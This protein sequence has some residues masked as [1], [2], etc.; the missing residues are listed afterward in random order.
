MPD[1]DLQRDV[2]AIAKAEEISSV[3]LEVLQERSG[4]VR[5]LLEAERTIGDVGRV[6][7]VR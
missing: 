1:G 4:V 2:A 5:R 3:D 7:A 6:L